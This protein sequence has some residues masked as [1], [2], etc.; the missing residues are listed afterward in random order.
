[1]RIGELANRTGVAEATLR[2]WERR[3]G[4]PVPHRTEGGHRLYGDTDVERIQRVLQLIGTGWAVHA[5]VRRIGRE[6]RAGD[7]EGQPGPLSSYAPRLES[8]IRAIDEDQMRRIYS[9]LFTAGR[10][11]EAVDLA[12]AC[13]G[14]VSTERPDLLAAARGASLAVEAFSAMLLEPHPTTKGT[15]VLAAVGTYRGCISQLYGTALV[16]A[17]AGWR[18]FTLDA[19]GA[20][21]NLLGAAAHRTNAGVAVLIGRQPAPLGELLSAIRLP[22]GCVLVGVGDTFSSLTDDP[23]HGFA[24]HRGSY[25]LLANRVDELRSIALR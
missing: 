7:G 3:H 22:R 12:M 9:E 6:A 19:D 20:A 8:A 24:I 21:P 23:A 16:L 4:F 25:S 14:T 11:G 18:A 5:A 2:A 10:T 13:I 1:M 15:A 17:D